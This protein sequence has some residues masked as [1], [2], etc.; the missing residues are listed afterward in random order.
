M[1]IRSKIRSFSSLMIATVAGTLL[2]GQAEAQVTAEQGYPSQITLKWDENEQADGYRVC[3]KEKDKEWCILADLTKQPS[4][5]ILVR[6]KELHI[7]TQSVLSKW[8]TDRFIG[9]PMT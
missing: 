6:K 7:F 2:C 4:I 9:W 8:M 3:R 5:Q 1:K